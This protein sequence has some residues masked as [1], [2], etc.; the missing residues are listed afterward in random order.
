MLPYV[1]L[2][3]ISLLIETLHPA[4][5]TFSMLS[6]SFEI[7][8]RDQLLTTNLYDGYIA[9]IPIGQFTK[10][11]STLV[12]AYTHTNRWITDGGLAIDEGEDIERTHTK[13]I[14]TLFPDSSEGTQVNNN[15]IALIPNPWYWTKGMPPSNDDQL[16]PGW[17]TI[18]Q[19][20]VT[21]NDIGLVLDGNA[22][23]NY[24]ATFWGNTT[25]NGN[26]NFN[27]NLN[28][29]GTLSVNGVTNLR[30][31]TLT[32]LTSS[33]NVTFNGSLVTTSNATRMNLGGTV[34][35]T[36]GRQYFTNNRNT[37]DE[38]WA[39]DVCPSQEGGGS[40]DNNA[41][42]TQAFTKSGI[43]FYGITVTANR[44]TAGN[45]DLVFT[46]PWR[47][48]SNEEPVRPAQ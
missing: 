48:A 5:S 15:S 23:F 43:S 47:F 3:Q 2:R 1:L 25:F 17:V 33:G 6:I 29:N 16:R 42:A 30:N 38:F 45:L 31:V 28:V 40:A 8:S 7:V 20:N 26:V 24:D 14:S 39:R 32:N 13:Y 36:N 12:G 41:W 4:T 44:N 11:N 37:R 27:N 46:P 18:D 19:R 34:W 22:I 10:E 21:T 35:G 9:E